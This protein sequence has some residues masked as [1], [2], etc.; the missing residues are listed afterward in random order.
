MNPAP[1]NASLQTRA[2]EYGFIRT[3]NAG[4]ENDPPMVFMGGSFVE[5]AF[6]LEKDQFVAQVERNLAERGVRYQCSMQGTQVR[7][8][9]TS[10]IRY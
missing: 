5:S 4:F 2:D 9:C 3:G 8:H 6:S 7:Q 10:T 1:I